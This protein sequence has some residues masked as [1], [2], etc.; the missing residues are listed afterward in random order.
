MAE[1][2]SAEKAEL[3]YRILGNA[4]EDV[5]TGFEATQ[6][7][8]YLYA[9]EQ[10]GPDA[11]KVKP[12]KNDF[13]NLHRAR[14]RFA[15]LDFD[16]FSEL[17]EEEFTALSVN[18]EKR[19]VIG[20]N[21]SV[22]DAK[23]AQLTGDARLGETVHLVGDDIRTFATIC[24][25]VVDRLDAWL[26]GT[27]SPTIGETSRAAVIVSSDTACTAKEVA[28]MDEDDLDVDLNPLAR[29]V[30]R[31]LAENSETGRRVLVDG[32]AI[33]GAF[34][35]E[36]KEAVEIAIAELEAEGFLRTASRGIGRKWPLVTPNVDLFA[37]FDSI[38]I[39]S[40]PYKDAVVLAKKILE[41]AS[42][43]RVADLHEQTG[44]SLRRFNPAIELVVSQIDDRRVSRTNDLTYPTPHFSIA[45]AD[46]VALNRFIKQLE[47]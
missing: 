37:T 47:S 45:P 12:V 34:P 11:P 3:A 19:H 40:E 26:E 18:I 21:L 5:L 38:A 1:A 41:L 7:A 39:G 8:V 43:V 10:R 4:H 46:K 24:Q 13:Q 42:A 17:T 27:P 25:R 28:R 22:V 2:Q 9:L 35:T 15:A 30:G 29:K 20:H 33:Q 6:K 16:P 31:W 44:W 32:E 14:E 23:F 36:G